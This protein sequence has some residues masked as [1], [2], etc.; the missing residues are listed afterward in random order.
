MWKRPYWTRGLVSTCSLLRLQAV[1]AGRIENYNHHPICSRQVNQNSQGTIEDVLVQVDKFYY[2]LEFIFLDTKLVNVGANYVP[3]IL[4]RPFFATSNVII[5]CRNGVM[6]V[7][8]RN[9]TLELNIFHLRK[10]AH[11]P[12]GGGSRRGLS[13]LYHPR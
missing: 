10:K 8:F 6:Q 5:N 2:P 13:D 1:G 11:A 4:G 9:M 12:S 7:T 3:I